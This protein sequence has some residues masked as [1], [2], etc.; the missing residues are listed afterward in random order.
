MR[1]LIC[2]LMIALMLAGCTGKQQTAATE[3]ENAVTFTDDLGRTVTVSN[4]Q[5]V[6]CLLGSFAEVWHR[7]T[8]ETAALKLSGTCASCPNRNVCHAC[9]AMAMTE[10]G[11][12]SGIP[13]YL[14]K[15]AQHMQKIARETLFPGET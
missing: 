14:C 9:A 4:P 6:A 2:F 7:L 15:T 13:T 12:A 8:E 11:S 3:P 10:T 1:K 5:R